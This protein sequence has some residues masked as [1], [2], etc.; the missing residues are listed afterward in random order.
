M[1]PYWMI[2]GW[3]LFGLAFVGQA[4][5]DGTGQPVAAWQVKT[6]DGRQIDSSSLKGKVVLVHFWATWC[7]PCREEMPA[8]DA[9]YRQ[10]AKDGLEVVAISLDDDA[11]RAK[12]RDFVRTYSFP[13]AMM[14]DARVDG[15]GRIWVL[16]LSFLIDRKGVLREDGWTGERRIDAASLDRIVL[17]LL[18]ER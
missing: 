14:R 15:F 13:V 3:L 17:P 18:S 9:F 11:D 10:H 1:K 7:P 2:L 8:L 12:V 6:L 16:P 4:V 5:A